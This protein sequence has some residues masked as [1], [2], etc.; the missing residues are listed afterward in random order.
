MPYSLVVV[1]PYDAIACVAPVAH[2]E[3]KITAAPTR[4]FFHLPDAV[5]PFL[6]MHPLILETYLEDMYLPK[7]ARE[8]VR[9]FFQL[10]QVNI[11]LTEVA[12]QETVVLNEHMLTDQGT[13]T[14]QLSR[15]SCGVR[16]TI[17]P[18]VRTL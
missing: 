7:P 9:A 10:G 8:N 1:M 18:P 12:K 16:F 3:K 17:I 15:T 2:L 5:Q 6:R 14:L 11:G 4:V 13:T